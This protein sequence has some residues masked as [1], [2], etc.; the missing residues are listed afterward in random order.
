MMKRSQSQ[1][2]SKK[3]LRGKESKIQRMK[4]LTEVMTMT[5]HYRLIKERYLKIWMNIQMQMK[6][7]MKE[8][9]RTARVKLNQ[10][11]SGRLEDREYIQNM[12][13]R[14]SFIREYVM[15]SSDK[16]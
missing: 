8:M 16:S 2:Q 12:N 7:T 3:V 6:M 1:K 15:R 11:Q 5:M 14:S 13:Q 10:S 9:M 4:K